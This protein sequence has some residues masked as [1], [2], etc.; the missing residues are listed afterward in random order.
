LS[1]GR[2]ESRKKKERGDRGKKIGGGSSCVK[3]HFI[4]PQITGEK[5]ATMTE[6]ETEQVSCKKERDL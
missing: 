5:V 1:R 2:K 6:K 3:V 4:Q